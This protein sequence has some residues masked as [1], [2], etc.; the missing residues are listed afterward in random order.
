MAKLPHPIQY[1]GSKR[2]LAPKILQFL[3][4]K[5]GRLVEPFAGTAALSIAAA[6]GDRCQLFWLNDLNQPLVQLLESIVER[7]AEIASDYA[8]LWNAQQSHSI[9]HYYQ[10]REQFNQTQDPTLFLYLLARCV[11]GAVRYNRQGDFNQSPDKRRKGTRPETMRKTIEAV[12]ELLRGKCLLTDLDY[13]DV[14]AA[15]QPDDIVYMDPPYQGVCGQK[16][17]RYCAGIEIDRFIA[18][19]EELNNRKIAFAISY[20]GHRGQKRFGEDLPEKL[21]LQKIQLEGGRSSQATLLGK[22]EMT[23][24]SL[25][26]SKAL[27]KSCL[28]QQHHTS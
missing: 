23:V 5:I 4:Q 15:V 28:K 10:V 9:E 21:C 25:Y 6:A 18:A 7:P 27:T 19:L 1:Q 14:L 20:D 13:R 2:N 22:V 3:P 8:R 24:E 11:K 16:D 17:G 12:S 26:L